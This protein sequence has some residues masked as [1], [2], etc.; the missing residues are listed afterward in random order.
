MAV[1]ILVFGGDDFDALNRVIQ[2]V[3]SRT[4]SPRFLA[5]FARGI[6]PRELS[7]AEVDR[8]LPYFIEADGDTVRAGLRFLAAILLFE[9]RGL[10][11]P[12]FET[13]TVRSQAWRLIEVALPYIEGQPYCDWL[14]VVELITKYDVSRTS[15]LLSQALM[16]ENLNLVIHA[17]QKLAELA[18][19][20]LYRS[21]Y[22]KDLGEREITRPSPPVAAPNTRLAR[23]R[24]SHPPAQVVILD[25]VQQTH[26]R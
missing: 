21:C 1:D 2:L 5:S 25:W 15:S 8:L 20:N 18:A 11:P 22:V 19:K 10:Q 3:D 23:S 12:C 16:N 9:K 26:G 14:E 13:E 24:G 4:V 7:V 6:G 17:Q